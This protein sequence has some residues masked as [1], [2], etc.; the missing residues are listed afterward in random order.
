MSYF[1]FLVYHLIHFCALFDR[2]HDDLRYKRR[3]KERN[4]RH[5]KGRRENRMRKERNEKRKEEKGEEE[6][7]ERYGG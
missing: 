6:G 1:Y 3:G 4:S 2:K 5:I 7:R